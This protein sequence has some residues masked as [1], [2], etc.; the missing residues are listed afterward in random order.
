MMLALIYFNHAAMFDFFFKKR[1][2]AK[3]AELTQLHLEQKEQAE[4]AIA[5]AKFAH[6]QSEKEAQ[7]H[8][9]KQFSG[10]EDAALAFILQSDFADARFQAVQHI[11]SQAALEQVSQA[12]RNSDRRVS[13]FAQEKLAL[14]QKAQKMTELAA[15]C[16]QRGA[17]LL[18]HP[19]VLVNQL[20]EWDK[21]RL[22]LGEYGAT[23][24]NIKTEL[25]ARLDAQ[26]ELQR[27]ALQI[28]S[29]LRSLVDTNS[30]VQPIELE[31]AQLIDLE[32]QWQQI[33]TNPLLVSL[34]KN[35]SVQLE[36]NLTQAKSH[37]QNKATVARVL[38]ERNEALL[39]WETDAEL[40]LE[41]VCAKWKTWTIAAANLSPDQLQL[42]E[43]QE[44]DYATLVAKL[45]TTNV[46]ANAKMSHAKKSESVPAD[47]QNTDETILKTAI[48]HQATIAA[49]EQALEEGSLQQA[50]DLDKSLRAASNPI[51]GE[52]A[53]RLVG[54]RAELMRL[55]DWAKWGGNVSRE[56][57][58][59]VA[60][61][62][63]NSELAAPELA[64]Q[65]GGLRA[66][67]KELDRTSGS[68]P[69]AIWERFDQAC[70]CAYEVADAFF[71][72]QAQI[73]QANL[74]IAQAQLIALDGA[75]VAANEQ[76]SNA[77]PDWKALQSLV[78]QAKIEWRKIGAVDRKHKSRLESEFT[79][80]LAVLERPLIEARQAA[81]QVR[82]QL[83]AS[84]ADLV[85]S[86]RDAA[87]KV[88]QA[89]QRW[90]QEALALP[91]ER[92]DEQR[93]WKQFRAACDAIFEQRKANMDSQ[94]QRRQQQA[95]EKQACCE[96][97]EQLLIENPS[98]S[99]AQINAVLRTAKQEWRELSAQNRGMETRFDA[100]VSALE[101]QLS[102]LDK[103]AKQAQLELLHAKIAICQ[104][105]ESAID[106]L[107]VSESQIAAWEADWE[108]KNQA[109]GK[110]IGS[111][112]QLNKAVQK[113]FSNALAALKNGRDSTKVDRASVGVQLDELLLKLE[114]LAGLPS[115]T[116]LT[117]QRLQMQVKGL[118][119]ALKNRE[120][121][122]SFDDHL[123]ALCALP[124]QFNEQQRQ[125]VQQILLSS[126]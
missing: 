48:D 19:I 35:Y 121:A 74:A 78:A 64:K 58:I 47:K 87:D 55:L 22:A 32:Q 50:L 73:R 18:A 72:E 79:E 124:V 29:A 12:M 43:Q 37:L 15:A 82:E 112:A 90:Q 80:K 119:S 20:T 123:T 125:R 86:D 101:Q 16:A 88:Q 14:I 11:H 25:D 31:Q 59:K 122:D 24:L 56:E 106:L 6:K 1:T 75:I 98:A 77:T 85:A 117:Q 96:K 76:T 63:V 27:Q 116:E 30:S 60:E 67:W 34:P 110:L 118:Q 23:L 41:L 49:L 81:L 61:G 70:N 5:A 107:E 105:V 54:L 28:S 93:L 39:A 21:E 40:A 33:Q 109:G 38:H 100:A 7:L 53:N 26:L 120:N 95:N 114:I 36:Q 69:R 71:K 108:E 84:V 113:R 111:S 62:L 2:A 4:T 8:Q 94:K 45:A 92:K 65:V 103:V 83:I 9:A 13:K 44:A 99:S 52:L 10:Q 66:R 89:Q 68:A 17:E 102:E 3:A 57:L 42:V 126:N 46:I 104:Q 97:L 91:L 115:P 51:K